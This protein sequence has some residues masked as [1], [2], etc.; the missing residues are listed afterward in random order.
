MPFGAQGGFLTVTLAFGL[1]KAGVAADAI[2]T[3]I[4][5]SYLPH[6]WK[7][8]WAPLVDLTWTRRRWYAATSNSEW[9]SSGSGGVTGE[10]RPGSERK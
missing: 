1:E 7:F 10:A 6:T 3:L 8:A 2:A 5:L 9:G 4:A